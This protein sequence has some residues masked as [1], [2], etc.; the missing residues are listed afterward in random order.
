MKVLH[1]ITGLNTGGAE[2]VLFRLVQ[3]DRENAHEVVSLMDE[4]TYGPQLRELGVPVR[5]LG[6]RRGRFSARA[7]AEL[8]G[9]IRQ[10]RPDVV[11]TWMYHA[12]LIGGLAARMAGCRAVVWGIR[13]GTLDPIRSRRSTRAVALLCARL[14]KSVPERI[15]VCAESAAEIHASL[16]YDRARMAVIPN[17]YDLETYR[18]NVSEKYKLREELRVTLDTKLIVMI[19]RWHP[20]KSYDTLVSAAKFA[21]RSQEKTAFIM[22][23][24]NID[25]QNCNLVDLIRRSELEKSVILLGERRDIPRILAGADIATLS[26]V[27]EAFPNVLAE[28]MACGTPCVATDVGDAALIIGDTGIVVPPRNPEALA[29]GWLKLLSLTPEERRRLGMAARKR[30]AEHFSIERMVER[31]RSLY[32][33]VVNSTGRG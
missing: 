8:V 6:M 21:V 29:Q 18:P 30:I 2:A 14:S 1:V 23:G 11:Q 15:V 13:N 27:A 33:E 5:A 10:R 17:G 9:I 22:V 26:S 7:F 12:D 19:G 32:E 31:Y 24:T 3:A 4:G 20:D 16:G 25:R 28:A